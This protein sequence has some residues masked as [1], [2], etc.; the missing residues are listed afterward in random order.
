MMFQMVDDGAGELVSLERVR[1]SPVYQ[2]VNQ[3][4]AGEIMG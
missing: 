4:H 1:P 3:L 2:T